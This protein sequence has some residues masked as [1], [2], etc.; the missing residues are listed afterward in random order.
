MGNVAK[1]KFYS[2]LIWIH[3][4]VWTVVESYFKNDDNIKINLNPG[5]KFP[6][7]TI[8]GKALEKN[9]NI[10]DGEISI[11]IPYI[12]K[13]I[14]GHIN[15]KKEDIPFDPSNKYDNNDGLINRYF[16]I[17]KEKVITLYTEYSLPKRIKGEKEINKN[18]ADFER[19]KIKQEIYQAQLKPILD[20]ILKSEENKEKKPINYLF[21]LRFSDFLKI[22]VNHYE[23]EK[24][25][26]EINK[27]IYGKESTKLDNFKVYEDCKD[28]FSKDVKKQ[29][30]YRDYFI[31]LIDGKVPK[32]SEKKIKKPVKKDN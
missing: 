22:Y 11:N 1:K 3:T 18:L 4:F 19:R 14:V 7:V 20:I 27:N 32:I 6:I 23:G 21:N 5:K 30:R 29:E 2:C 25:S 10:K 16:Q 28:K 26:G 8:S 15:H 24:I 13:L 31:D 17:L 12:T 9:N